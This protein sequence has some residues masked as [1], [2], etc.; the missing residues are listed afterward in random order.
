LNVRRPD[1]HGGQNTQCHSG[2]AEQGAI[3]PLKRMS[4]DQGDIE[5]EWYSHLKP[6]RGINRTN[7]DE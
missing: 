2:D 4:A 5:H 6:G 3:W 1:A 7:N